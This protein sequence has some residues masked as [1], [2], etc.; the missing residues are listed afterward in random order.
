MELEADED[1]WGGHMIRAIGV[2]FAVVVA[3]GL[4]LASAPP[5]SADRYDKYYED[6]GVDVADRPF[7]DWLVDDGNYVLIPPNAKNEGSFKPLLR[8][9]YDTCGLVSPALTKNDETIHIRSISGPSIVTEGGTAVQ[10]N[11]TTHPV[12]MPHH[13]IYTD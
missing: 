2:V 7:F 4:G 13:R 5:A 6:F 1:Y 3:V 9:G 8:L 12:R 11:L 10:V